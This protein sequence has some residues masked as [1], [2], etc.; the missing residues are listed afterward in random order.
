MLASNPWMNSLVVLVTE[1]RPRRMNMLPGNQD[2]W[3]IWAVARRLSCRKVG[4]LVIIVELAKSCW[5][6]PNDH[7][8]RDRCCMRRYFTCLLPTNLLV[9]P[10]LP[11]ISGLTFQV[12]VLPRIEPAWCH[13]S[14]ESRPTA[15]ENKPKLQLS[16]TWGRPLA[17]HG[18]RAKWSYREAKD[19]NGDDA[20]KQKWKKWK[21]KSYALLSSVVSKWKTRNDQ[22]QNESNTRWI[23]RNRRLSSKRWRIPNFLLR[24][25]DENTQL[26]SKCWEVGNLGGW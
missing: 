9:E 8:K 17:R 14:A 15:F 1:D 21:T 4:A 19:S 7:W 26:L 16:T 2:F 6:R 10:C 22:K 20:K 12:A 3:S 18:R 24:R 5:H 25:P 13:G 23:T 11:K